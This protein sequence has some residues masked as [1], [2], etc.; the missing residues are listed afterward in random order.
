MDS[1]NEATLDRF[2]L[3]LCQDWCAPG[4]YSSLPLGSLAALLN[5]VIVANTSVGS[6][7]ALGSTPNW[8]LLLHPNPNTA[9]LIVTMILWS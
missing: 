4:H 6:D 3:C 2:H 5:F 9:P 8:W 1:T 7:R